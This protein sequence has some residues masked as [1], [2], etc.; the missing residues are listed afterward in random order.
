MKT[1]TNIMGIMGIMGI[2]LSARAETASLTTVT[3]IGVAL[4]QNNVV[5]GANIAVTANGNK[6]TIANTA[7]SGTTLNSNQLNAVNNA[8]TNGAPSG[9]NFNFLPYNY[10]TLGG[11]NVFSNNNTV[12]AQEWLVGANVS[13]NGTV[14]ASQ[15]HEF[16]MLFPAYASSTALNGFLGVNATALNVNTLD[17]GSVNSGGWGVSQ[18][19]LDTGAAYNSASTR[20]W[21]ID[22]SGNLY[23]YQSNPTYSLGLANAKIATAYI[24]NTVTGDLTTGG[25]WTGIITNGLQIWASTTNFVPP[26]DTNHIWLATATNAP[27]YFFVSSN[28]VWIRK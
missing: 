10:P 23:P 16:W 14:T 5:A 7:A 12:L 17:V 28:G 20:W 1:F 19:F 25:L 4:L 26:V 2:M 27:G 6:I 15:A 8:V 24:S 18:I 21:T 22:S 13:G 11:A 9:G 3:N